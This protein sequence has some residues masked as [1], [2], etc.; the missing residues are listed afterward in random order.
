M[1]SSRSTTAYWHRS[2]LT[3]RTG[4][5]LWRRFPSR[6]QAAHGG[7]LRA[8]AEPRGVADGRTVGGS[9]FV[10]CGVHLTRACRVVVS[11]SRGVSH[12]SILHPY[13]QCFKHVSRRWS[14]FHPSPKRRRQVWSTSHPHQRVCSLF[15]WLSILHPRQRCPNRRRQLWST[16]HPHQRVC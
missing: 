14:I 3:G 16:S 9:V 15:Q 8:G 1:R 10:A 5:S 12:W 13:Q 7:R 6:R 2:D 11:A 4:R